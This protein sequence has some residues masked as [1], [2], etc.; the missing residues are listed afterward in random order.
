MILLLIEICSYSA[1]SLAKAFNTN[2]TICHT[3]TPTEPV[4]H[5]LLSE[6]NANCNT[7]MVEMSRT[8]T[9]VSAEEQILRIT[10][11]VIQF[12]FLIYM[13]D[14]ISKLDAYYS[15]RDIMLSDYSIM[16]KK[17]PRQPNIQAKLR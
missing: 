9:E 5:R 3:L 4:V 16:L 15:E 6:G 1:L 2:F 12:L 10:S 13:R 7:F 11:F 17:I 8:E 14:H